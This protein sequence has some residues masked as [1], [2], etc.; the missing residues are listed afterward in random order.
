MSQLITA[1]AYWRM[2]SSP[3]E[4]SIP[5]QRAEMLPRCQLAG[6][7][8]VPGGEF[9][10]EAKSGGSMR[11][12]DSFL[13]MLRFCQ[14]RHAAREP[15]DCIVCFDTSRFSR[16]SS[17]ETAHYIW[18]FQRAGVHRVLTWERWFDFR[19]EEDRAI[20]LL[21]QDFTNNRFLRDL[22]LKI[23]RGKKDVAQA[24]FFTG[25]VVPY[26]FDRMLVDERGR[27][28]ERIR[29]G[30]QFRLKRKGWR[31]VLAPIPEDDPEPARQ[32]QRQTAVWLYEYFAA[33]NVSYRHLAFLLNERGVPGP[34]SHYHRQK[35]TPG[36]FRW[37]VRAVRGARHARTARRVASAARWS[38]AA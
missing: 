6:V 1:V 24:G 7:N 27:P 35:E 18:E 16:A 37:T 4:K 12:R 10:D 28:V 19:R 22:S 31:L 2:S 32:L 36:Q 17:I 30:E 21:Q 15:V 25:G 26:G 20:F 34:G 13:E 33:N 14:K 3:Q 38:T 11:K 5:Q 9:K 8:L 29:R 23:L